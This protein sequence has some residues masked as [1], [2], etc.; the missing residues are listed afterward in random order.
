MVAICGHSCILYVVGVVN[1]ARAQMPNPCAPV[2][3]YTTTPCL[4]STIVT[5]TSTPDW[6]SSTTPDWTSSTTP[7]WTSSTTPDWTSTTT[8]LATTTSS[9]PSVNDLINK[10]QDA[11]NQLPAPCST[12]AP[13]L[14]TITTTPIMV[15]NG[16]PCATFAP[17]AANM[18]MLYPEQEVPVVMESYAQSK[19]E[20]YLFAMCACAGSFTVVYMRSSKW[21]THSIRA[22]NL[23]EGR[24]LMGSESDSALE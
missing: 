22:L 13:G 5:S 17:S 6:T 20:V 21:K 10:L 14:A 9:P 8:P 7:D 18:S 11:V 19:W 4:T 3:T 12:I 2:A 1:F 23:E 15:Y 16:T 24:H